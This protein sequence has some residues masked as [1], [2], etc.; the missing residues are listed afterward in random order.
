LTACALGGQ[1]PPRLARAARI[2]AASL[3]LSGISASIYF[4]SPGQKWRNSLMN[5]NAPDFSPAGILAWLRTAIPIG[6]RVLFGDLRRAVFAVVAIAVVA[7][8]VIGVVRLRRSGEWRW[9]TE[10][11][12]LPDALRWGI[13]AAGFYL[14]YL[15]SLATLLVSPHFPDYAAQYPALLLALALVCTVATVAEV[16]SGRLNAAF[17]AA[18]TI[19]VVVF[20]TTP[21]IRHN[22]ASFREEAAFGRLREAVFTRVLEI[23]R[24]RGATG[25]IL[26][27]APGRSIGGT[28][29]PPW[30]ISAYFRWLGRDDLVVVID[31]NYDFAARPLDREYVTVDAS[32]FWTP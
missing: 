26:T 19:L 22:V 18:C 5:V 2:L 25:F 27:H 15:A 24:E 1:R 21:A 17:A 8:L 20:I 9:P 16:V 30:G 23:N 7:A 4:A 12:D 3:A 11:A 13:F 10:S 31:N 6:Y 28:M 29:E 14:A 32:R